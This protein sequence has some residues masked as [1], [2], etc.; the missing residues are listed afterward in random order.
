MAHVTIEYMILVPVLIA[1]IFIFPFVATVMLN[2]WTDQRRSLELQDLTAQLGSSVL[3]L[4][5]S[6]NHGSISSGSLTMKV[7]IPAYIDGHYYTITL[8]NATQPNLSDSPKILKLTL[9]LIGVDG[10]AT[11]LVTLGENADWNNSGVYFSNTISL[12][13]ATKVSDSIHLTFENGGT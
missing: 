3:Q 1:Q 13:N 5:Y 2:T 4:Y 11:T 7:D 8:S 12:I 6:I 9:N 10:E